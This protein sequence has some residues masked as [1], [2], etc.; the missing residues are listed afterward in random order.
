MADQ[1]LTGAVPFDGEDAFAIGM[2]HLQ[3]PLPTPALQG[4]DERRLFEVIRRMTMKD[5]LDR[6]DSCE[7]LLASFRG[8]AVAP[9][10]AALAGAVPAGPP[11]RSVPLAPTTPIG[12]ATA[13]PAT[14]TSGRRAVTPPAATPRT[15]PL[16]WLLAVA[17]VAAGGWWAV[18]IRGAPTA[19]VAPPPVTV[20][21]ETVLVTVPPETLVASV[22]MPVP[23]SAASGVS[24][25][26]AETVAAAPA[27]WGTDSGSLKL[28]GL[29]RGSSVLIDESPVTSA[30]TRLP[31][32]RHFLGV[33][34][35]MHEFYEDTVL[36]EAGILTELQP[37]L[38]PQGGRRDLRRRRLERRLADGDPRADSLGGCDRPIANYNLGNRCYEVRPRPR[39]TVR[40]SLPEGASAAP[41]PSL[42]LV[43]VAADGR[44]L[45]VQP[46]RPSADSLF[47]AAARRTAAGLSWHPALKNG[48]P[49]DGWTQWLATPAR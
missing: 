5:P 19:P 36:I 39:E 21:P 30:V 34:A 1:C 31:A 10:V 42:L 25:P 41:G 47:E 14:R 13:G 8:E 29:P 24:L 3:S 4:A 20:A 46:L 16:P 44:V 40:V 32:G 37:V 48:L 18:R 49:V 11:A 27:P 12:P 6:F 38:T 17:A 2:Q 26:P 28:V 15:S 9:S 33:S 35:P 22:P 45:E 43:R 7:A 23:D